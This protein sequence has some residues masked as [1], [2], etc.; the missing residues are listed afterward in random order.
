MVFYKDIP[1]LALLVVLELFLDHTDHDIV[2]Y[3]TALVHDLLR[4]ATKRSLL[5]DLGA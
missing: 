1:S 4:L 2:A 5:G 3:E